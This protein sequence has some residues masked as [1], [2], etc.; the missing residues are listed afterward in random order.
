MKKFTAMVMVA[1]IA[2][3]MVFAQ[4]GSEEVKEVELSRVQA[5]IKEAEGMTLSE[6]AQK[7]IEESN[8][9]TFYG[10]GNSSRG[11]TAL[12]NFI[13]Y[14]QTIDP[15][16]TLTPEWSQPKNNSIFT[17]LAADGVKAEGTY[18]MTLIQDGNQIESKMVQTGLLDRFIPKEWA[19]ANGTTAAE[20]EGYLP[21]QTLNKVFMYNCTGSKSYDNFWDFVAP[22]EHGLFMDVDSEVVGKNFLY[23]LTSPQYAKEV[24]AAYD[25]LSAEE[26]AVF[27]PTIKAVSGDAEG[28][29]LDENGKYALAWIKLWVESYNAQTDDGP[30]CNTL[31]EASRNPILSARTTSRSQLTKM[32]I[33]VSAAT[34]T[35]TISSLQRTLHFHGQLVHSSHTWLRKSTASLLGVRISVDTHPTQSWLKRM[36]RSSTTRL[37]E[38]LKMA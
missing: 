29:G 21:L 14:L 35:A 23:M 4:G 13:A 3:L 37:E 26:K 22:G 33:Q 25:A 38:W 28:L 17:M 36:K 9:K 5:I 2:T 18:A 34:A 16:Y 11:K 19:E 20:Y 27:D 15:S 8:G 32:D 7:A 12:P 6:L 24:K 1:L 31:L 30:I 10:L